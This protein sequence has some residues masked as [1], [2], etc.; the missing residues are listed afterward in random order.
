MD[1]QNQWDRITAVSGIF[2]ALCALFISVWQ[3]YLSREHNRLSVMPQLAINL[4]WHFENKSGLFVYNQ[5][6]G[7]ARIKRVSIFLD[8][9]LLHPYKG[10]QQIGDALIASQEKIT[11]QNSLLSAHYLYPGD[12][13]DKSE[14]VTFL[15]IPERII[16]SD[17]VNSFNAFFA[18]RVQVS[19]EYCS[20]YDECKLIRYP[21]N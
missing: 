20:F 6:L 11:E 12:I 1:K 9:K 18:K 19:I 2:I 3:G 7:P 10:L 16:K 4:D 17:K 21:Q 13:I 14:M 15:G 8:G 5:G